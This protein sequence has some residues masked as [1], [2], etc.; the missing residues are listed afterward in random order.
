M[1][2]EG[3][4][5]KG[6]GARVWGRNTQGGG[7]GG[8]PAPNKRKK[9]SKRRSPTTAGGEAGGEGEKKH[10]RGGDI[11]FFSERRKEVMADEANRGEIRNIKLN[12]EFN[13]SRVAEL[14]DKLARAEVID[15]SKLSGDTIRFGPR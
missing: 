12:Q 8:P 4:A 14:E 3:G 10:S 6:R 9:K 2:A 15:V 5:Q 7:G 11:P 13:D 1:G